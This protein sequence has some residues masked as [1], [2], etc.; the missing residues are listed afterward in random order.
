M[1][2][3]GVSQNKVTINA[4]E[5]ANELTDV[6]LSNKKVGELGRDLR[7]AKEGPSKKL[8]DAITTV[9]EISTLSWDRANLGERQLSD[10]LLPIEV[11][12][13]IQPSRIR[14]EEDEF[15]ENLK[16]PVEL[17]EK[18]DILGV[19]EL[20]DVISQIY[21]SRKVEPSFAERASD[22]HSKSV[23]L[24][25]VIAQSVS[26]KGMMRFDGMNASYPIFLMVDL[27]KEFYYNAPVMDV[28]RLYIRQWYENLGVS[29]A[30]KATAPSTE[31]E[32]R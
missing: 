14:I 19:I 27:K 6:L 18:G 13:L 32:D 3:I 11:A 23:V 7:R 25:S 5:L 20:R 1:S 10:I 22:W 31:T 29:N 12:K 16:K 17:V 30:H 8:I 24:S 9:L 4:K 2:A 15:S 21:A 26:S 28:V